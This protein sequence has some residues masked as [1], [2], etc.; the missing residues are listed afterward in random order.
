MVY[1]VR[2]GILLSLFALLLAACGS[3]PTA[4]PRPA[5]T[6][7]AT[8]E[9]AATPL[10]PGAPTPTPKPA[11]MPTAT[12]LQTSA[13][14]PSGRDMEAYFGGKTIQIIVGASPGGGYDTFARVFAQHAGKHLPGSPR[15]VVR[16][17]PGAGQQLG[18]QY[19]MKADPDGYTTGLLAARFVKRELAGVDVPDFDLETMITLGTPSWVDVASAWYVEREEATTWDEVL[20]LGRDLNDGQ[21]DAG[22]SASLGPRF[23]ELKG[24]PIKVVYGYG[25][26]SEIAAAFDRGELDGTSRCGA[27][28]AMLFPEWIEEQFC[29]PVF[30]WG[31]E[32]EMD[33]IFT[34][35]L[36]LIGAPVPPH[37]FDIIETT[38][39]ERDVF[40]L[41]DVVNN[42][43]RTFLL[44]P[45]TPDD[46]I[47][48][49]RQAMEATVED[50]EFVEQSRILGYAASFGSPEA[51]DEALAAGRKSLED[52]QLFQLFKDLGGSAE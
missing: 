39:G 28:D 52:P 16:N 32:P 46:L 11:P 22:A 6:A 44:P 49:W 3:D 50:P 33:P 5:P 31:A 9:P 42:T 14:T 29:V 10:P 4:T 36:K 20:A 26:S 13:P 8:P 2:T 1:M 45:G 23:V 12:P 30:R 19:T 21:T 37:I 15:F 47:A 7:T 24:G 25:G 48:V 41:V 18:L 34:D 40:K 35:W 27:D 17:I 43:G 38:Q 51:I